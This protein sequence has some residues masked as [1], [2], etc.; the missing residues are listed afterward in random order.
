MARED[1]PEPRM[2]AEQLRKPAGE[3][4]GQI[5][6]TMDRVNEPLFDLT[7]A[8]IRPTDGERV[9]EIGFGTGS[10]IHRLFRGAEGLE[11]YGVDYSPEMVEIATRKNADLVDSGQLRL[12]TGESDDL[13]FDDHFFDKVFCNM[14]VYFWDRPADH[15]REI[16]RVLKSGGRFYTG[17]RTRD[18]MLQFPFVH[19]GFVLYEPEEWMGL[20]EANGFRG[21]EAGRQLDPEIENDE[22]AIRLE[23]V[24]VGAQ[25]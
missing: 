4:A 21:W 15:L 14:V 8:A 19:F 22:G 5:G 13:P 7:V 20:L 25:R 12:A 24:C 1:Q 6:D 3:P 18:S 23:S 9:L 2:I 16:R 11:V 10:F 17:M